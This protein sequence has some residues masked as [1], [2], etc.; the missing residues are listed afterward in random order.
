MPCPLQLLFEL[1]GQALTASQVD[2]LVCRPVAPNDIHDG[3]FRVSQWG[4]D[5]VR[6]KMRRSLVITGLQMGRLFWIL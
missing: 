6:L 1:P 5:G 2:G 4:R 3:V